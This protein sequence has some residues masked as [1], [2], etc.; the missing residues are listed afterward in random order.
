MITETIRKSLSRAFCLIALTCISITAGAKNNVSNDYSQSGDTIKSSFSLNNPKFSQILK[1]LQQFA[2]DLQQ[3]FPDGI[4][5]PVDLNLKFD[6]NLDLTTS[7]P[8]LI[9]QVIYNTLAG[10]DGMVNQLKDKE[11][12]KFDQKTL[13]K[14][15][16]QFRKRS[17][18]EI[19]KLC[20]GD[21]QTQKELKHKIQKLLDGI[22]IKE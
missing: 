18:K 16:K 12:K 9:I 10:E 8:F 4:Q 2:D 3:K 13:N 17:N 19:R 22:Q 5:E 14:L 6:F 21:R 15:K 7:Q 11:I 20:K 1:S